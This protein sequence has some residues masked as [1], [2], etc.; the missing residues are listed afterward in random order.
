MIPRVKLRPTYGFD[1]VQDQSMKAY[2]GCWTSQA[3]ASHR[4]RD[5]VLKVWKT[6]PKDAW[7]HEGCYEGHSCYWLK[8]EEGK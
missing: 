4:E 3:I 8:L 6:K 1:T 7:T 5:E 2:P